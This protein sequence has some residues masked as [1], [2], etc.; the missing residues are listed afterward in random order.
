V[1]C[2]CHHLFFIP[3]SLLILWHFDR[4]RKAS[5]LQRRQQVVTDAAAQNVDGS[6][7]GDEM[8]KQAGHQAAAIATA[9][10]EVGTPAAT[11][12]TAELSVKGDIRVALNNN[13][14]ANNDSNNL[15][16]LLGFRELLLGTLWVGFVSALTALAVPRPCVPVT[17]EMA[18]GGEVQ[19]SCFV[20]NVNM[21]NQVSGAVSVYG[22]SG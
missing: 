8:T 1:W 7:D 18:N 21:V 16:L 17:M 4:E 14:N 6:D 2:E 15:P 13:N 19:E 22:Q 12:E 9:A 3:A 5:L 11:A 10:A 20:N